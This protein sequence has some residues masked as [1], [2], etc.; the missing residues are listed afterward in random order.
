MKTPD[1]ADY[2][3]F[4]LYDPIP[5]PTKR[6][7]AH[8]ICLVVPDMDKAAAIIKE[9]AAATGYTTSARDPNRNQSETAVESLRSRW[10][11]SRI[12]GTEYG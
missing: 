9:R 10:H 7:S 12:N 5:E 3:E 4:M 8:H 11:A 2:V 6:G 1:S